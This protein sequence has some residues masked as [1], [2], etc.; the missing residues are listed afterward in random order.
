L[1][2][3]LLLLA[4]LLTQL[5]VQRPTQLPQLAT[6]LTLLLAQRPMLLPQLATLLT[7]LQLQLATQLTQLLVQPPTL[8]NLSKFQASRL[9][10]ERPPIRVAFLRF[11]TLHHLLK[12]KHGERP[13]IRRPKI[14][15]TVCNL[16]TRA[17]GRA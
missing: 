7:P 6:L 10:R 3:L 1:T 15:G 11:G 12:S 17:T 14:R 2:P 5:L 9:K 13:I 16:V 8:L 4:T